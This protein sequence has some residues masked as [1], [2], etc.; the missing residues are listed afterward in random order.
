MPDMT[1]EDE[2]SFPDI[3]ADP[4]AHS[5]LFDKLVSKVEPRSPSKVIYIVT[6]GEGGPSNYIASYFN[7]D[8]SPWVAIENDQ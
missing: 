2:T 6:P 4:E 3:L 7:A 1:T 8:E 5:A